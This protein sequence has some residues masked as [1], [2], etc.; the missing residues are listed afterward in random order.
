M[1]NE[2]NKQYDGWLASANYDQVAL[3]EPLPKLAPAYG[4][5]FKN[6][7]RYE[8]ENIKTESVRPCSRA[9]AA[10]KPI[11]VLMV[12]ISQGHKSIATGV[13]F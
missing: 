6:N 1:R 10:V 12:L 9:P 7:D 3:E 2:F 8:G 4:L 5:R 13:E 11:N